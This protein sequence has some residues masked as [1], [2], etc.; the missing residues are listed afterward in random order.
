MSPSPTYNPEVK[1]VIFDGKRFKVVLRDGRVFIGRVPRSRDL[2]VA[3][4]TL[5]RVL[6]R[7]YRRDLE[8]RSLQRTD[9]GYVLP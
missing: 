2:P 3:L 9:D 5:A 8:K 1:Q 7:H 6:T 4:E